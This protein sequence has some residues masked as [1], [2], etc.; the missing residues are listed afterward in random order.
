[1]TAELR[2]AIAQRESEIA[3]RVATMAMLSQN[4]AATEA[5]LARLNAMR[6]GSIEDVPAEK[7]TEYLA[8]MRT[9][10]SD[11]ASLRRV[12][13]EITRRLGSEGTEHGMASRDLARKRA[14][15]AALAHKKDVLETLRA[16]L[17]A[18]DALAEDRIARGG[19]NGVVSELL[20]LRI[21]VVDAVKRI[22]ENW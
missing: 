14:L 5:D 6:E 12:R 13:K 11:A 8:D 4:L 10:E 16:A 15:L 19:P 17:N 1:M 21:R 9:L 2:A 18:L 22:D 20:S 3:E 7:L